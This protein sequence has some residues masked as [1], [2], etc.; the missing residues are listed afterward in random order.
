M[1]FFEVVRVDEFTRFYDNESD[2]IY[3][4]HFGKLAINPFSDLKWKSKGRNLTNEIKIFL[5]WK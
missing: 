4:H 5:I 2:N 1:L 3:K